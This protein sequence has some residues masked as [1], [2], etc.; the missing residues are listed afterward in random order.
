MQ[1][2]TT[3]LLS[4]ASPWLTFCVP[5]FIGLAFFVIFPLLASVFLSFFSDIQC[6]DF[7]GLAHFRALIK[8]DAFVLAVKNTCFFYVIALPLVTVL[9]LVFANF[10]YNAAS[11]QKILKFASFYHIILPAASIM[12]FCDLLFSDGGLLTK[13]I[14]SLFSLSTSDLYQT[15]FSFFLLVALFV[16]KYGGYNFLLFSAAISRIPRAYYE[17]AQICGASALQCFRLITL[18]SL[19]RTLLLSVALSVVNSYKIYREAYLIGGYYPHKSM[20]LIQHYIHNNYQNMNFSRLCAV[21]GVILCCLIA[22]FGLVLFIG[23]LSKR[24]TNRRGHHA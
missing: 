8:S 19:K 22:V 16:L 4:R 20:Y 14:A 9:P 6:T 18:P 15:P 23:F 5:F 11:A 24:I 1:S 3:G 2:K 17:E 12:V 10:F 13:E 21:S 7:V